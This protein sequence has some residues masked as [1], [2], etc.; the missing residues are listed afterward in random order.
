MMEITG[1]LIDGV[2]DLT[3]MMAHGAMHE[4]C[5]IEVIKTTEDEAFKLLNTVN[6]CIHKNETLPDVQKY[7]EENNATV[8]DIDHRKNKLNIDE[9][10]EN[11]TEMKKLIRRMLSDNKGQDLD[12]RFKK[13][14]VKLQKDLGS[15]NDNQIDN[16]DVK[17]DTLDK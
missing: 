11:V 17:N 3:K 16:I 15:T 4:A 8:L 6:N 14:L 12:K 9:K 5:L 10:D 13:K 2:V 7:I 1:L